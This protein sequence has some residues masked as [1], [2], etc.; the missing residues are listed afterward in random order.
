MNQFDFNSEGNVEVTAGTSYT[1]Q[2]FSYDVEDGIAVMSTT[3]WASDL[4]GPIGTGRNFDVSNL[5]VG[6][7][8]IS[9]SVVDTNGTRTTVSVKIEV[10][11]GSVAIDPNNP[12]NIVL[13]IGSPNRFKTIINR[14][15]GRRI[16][17]KAH[18][19]DLS[20][21][22]PEFNDDYAK[23][24]VWSSE[25]LGGE[26][27]QGQIIRINTAKMGAGVHEIQASIGEHTATIIVNL[28]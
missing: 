9:A 19:L 27:A 17:L 7:H 23:N 6:V 18:A 28:R 12:D 22:N 25:S 13:T 3:L 5:S 1:L 4:D 15:V 20:L 21:S 16:R 11:E 2:T 24:T 10:K 8:N 26:F 14:K